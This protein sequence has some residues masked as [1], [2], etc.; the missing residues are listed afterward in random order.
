MAEVNRAPCPD[1]G[2]AL[3]PRA[4]FCPGCG[5]SLQ[6]GEGTRTDQNQQRLPPRLLQAGTRI[7]DRY[8]IDGVIGEGGMGVVYRGT[9]LQR[10]KL[11]AIKALHSNLMGD[12]EIRRRFRREAQLML[13]WNHKHVARVHDLIER[14][15]LLAF[16]M[17]YVDGPSLEDHAQRWGGK[18]P[19]D[20][21]RQIFTGVLEAMEE[22]HSVGVVHRDLKPQNILLSFTDNGVEPKIVDFGIAKILEGTTYTMT[23]ALLGTCRYMS[24]EQVQAPQNVGHRAD[25]YSLGVTLYRCV[26][27][28]CP[29]EGNNHFAVMM[30]HVEQAPEPPSDY[31][32]H[33]P[34]ALEA[35]MLK[36]LEKAREDRPPTCIA[37]REALEVALV[38]VTNARVEHESEHPRVIIEEDGNEMLLVPGGPFQLGAHR[39][40][41]YIDRFYLARYP[42]TN[43]QFATFVERTGYHPTDEEA[44]RF[45]AHF[46]NGKY[47][48]E[49][50]DHP[51]VFVSW[52]DARA[53][54]RWAA[55]RLPTEAEWEKAARGPDGNKYP[56]GR[57]EPSAEYA[58]FGQAR[59]KSYPVSGEG[60]TSAVGAF[61]RSA[62]PYGMEGMAGNVFEWCEDLDD[63]AFYTHGPDRNPR[64][65]INAGSAPH[66]IRGGCWRYDARSLRTFARASFQ[67][68]FR[69][70]TV[71]FRV[72]L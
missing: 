27:G 17:D 64:N 60:G 33:L 56:W 1:C 22:A 16:V 63:V 4:R 65:T 18:L 51:V 54:C 13:G 5:K 30:A 53:Y 58:N 72:A 38:D 41:V 45:L 8:L 14:E 31:R 43:R 57:D 70:D 61:P 9:D 2:E 71:G 3:P 23:G 21:I 36:A 35:L 62:S 47:L 19:W 28:R 32:P 10:D 69:L 42:V 37:F 67:P 20:E 59:A 66:V 52:L 29:F 55:R 12:P 48:P 6:P 39:R 68:T 49:L 11:V 34:P 26:T 40:T 15:E 25:I 7:A 24:P 46:R 50:A 44:K